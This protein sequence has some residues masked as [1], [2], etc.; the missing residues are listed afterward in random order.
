MLKPARYAAAWR[1]AGPASEG[2]VSRITNT[3]RKKA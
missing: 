3:A 2:A 1:G